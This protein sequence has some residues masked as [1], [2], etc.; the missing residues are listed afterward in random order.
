V[1]SF[2]AFQPV[3]DFGVLVRGVVV[4]DQMEVELWRC[5]GVDLLE[6]LA[7]SAESVG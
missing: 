3:P 6:K 5:L 7:S 4:H 1:E 2:V